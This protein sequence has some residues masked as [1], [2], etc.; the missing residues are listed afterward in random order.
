MSYVVW[1][2][3]ADGKRCHLTY[4]KNAKEAS[5]YLCEGVSLKDKWTENAAY[6]M[7]DDYK[8]R[9]QLTDS[10]INQD[11][12]IVASEKLKAFLE[13][14][15][16][17]EGNEFLPVAIINHKGRTAKEKY[18]VVNNV[19]PQ[20]AFDQAKSVYRRNTI[21]TT[22]IDTVK[23]L[24]VDLTKI[25]PTAQLFR[26][27]YFKSMIVVRQDLADKLKASGM[28]GFSFMTFDRYV[29]FKNS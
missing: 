13:E 16:A 6:A 17:G 5:A 4:L 7:D 12:V 18:F 15:G 28:T 11:E 25:K 9:I 26:L 21:D 23:T 24:V 1:D 20:D 10:L 8:T 14:N 27:K 2:D 3:C 19:D 29:A 22:Q